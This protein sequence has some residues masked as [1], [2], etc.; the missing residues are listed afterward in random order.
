[1]PNTVSPEY[2]RGGDGLN[3]LQE[4]KCPC[5]GGAIAF[6][7]SVQKMKCPYCDTEFEME[8]LESYDRELKNE[9]A[10]SMRWETAA[11]SEWAENEVDGLRS[12]VCQSCGGEIVAD[13]NTA[14]TSCPYCG[15]PVVMMKQF[16][17][18]LKPDYVIPFKL[19]KKA[20]KEALRKHY[21]GKKLL[22][23]IFK[24]E[25]H[26]D[27]VK[28]VYVPFWLFD[29]DVDANI[30]YKATRVRT[31]SDS[32]YD[33]IETSY[34]AVV[35]GGKIRF[36]RVPVDGSSNMPDDLMES[37][38][39]FDFS[40]AVDFQTAYLAG[41]LADKYDVDAEQ[42]IDRANE[43]IKRSTEESFAETV[44]NYNTVV[45]EDTRIR[46]E[47]SVAKYALYPV[48]L[49]NTSWNGERYLFAMNGQT[50]KLVGDLPLDK[51]AA[52]KWRIVLSVVCSAA[53]Y[54]VA[55]LLWLA[56][57]L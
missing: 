4:Y 17:G 14:A 13:A 35:R 28:G 1:M 54:G 44:R 48:W 39:P 37:V 36:E 51:K 45:P 16:S 5:C 7:S 8:T 52:R 26:I 30:R 33:Y 25:N 3:T 38:E 21:G 24:D 19:D 43:R 29:T 49:L 6:D 42:S 9:A 53:A 31:W 11:G 2:K 12:Y 34:Y 15:N 55:Q 10:D 40:D 27:E 23:K 46:F 32:E 57:I 20:A 56:G 47:N 41:Y 50:G 18:A 22:P